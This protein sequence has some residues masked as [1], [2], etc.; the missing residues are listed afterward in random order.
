MLVKSDYSPHAVPSRIWG[1]P[2]LE[3]AAPAWQ[4]EKKT[5]DPCNSISMRMSLQKESRSGSGDKELRKLN[6][7]KNPF[8]SG[9]R[10]GDAVK[11]A[12]R[13]HA[14]TGLS[15]GKLTK[16]SKTY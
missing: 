13:I 6:L 10:M 8:L 9:V 14:K 4:R 7:G 5:V 3:A 16:D 12:K 1:G 15:K 2:S 11:A